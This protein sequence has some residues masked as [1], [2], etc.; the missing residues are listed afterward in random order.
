M[1]IMNFTVVYIIFLIISNAYRIWRRT[2]TINKKGKEGTIHIRPICK[3]QVILYSVL[4]IGCVVEYFALGREINLWITVLGFILYLAGIFGR[5]WV[6]K[7]LGQYWSVDIE[8]KED[9]KLIKEGPFKYLRHPNSFLLQLEMTGIA[10]IPNS[11]YSLFLIWT[12]YLPL[13]LIRIYLEEKALIDKFG[14]E[15]LEY[16]KEVYALLPIKR[17]KREI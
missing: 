7:T 15:Y 3:V 10:L 8:I 1:E 9:H 16:R 14:E 5:E 4:A 13:T 11:Y 17:V 12:I 6:V 2:A